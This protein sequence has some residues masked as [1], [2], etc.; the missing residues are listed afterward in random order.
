M[1]L[2]TFPTAEKASKYVAEEIAAYIA[3]KNASNEKTV[4]G[5]AT[6]STPIQVYKELINFHQKG[7]SFK[8]V[9]TFNLDEYYPMGASE[10][11]SYH[12]YMHTHLFDHVD[13]SGENIHIPDGML[14]GD[15]VKEYCKK[16]EQKIKEVGGIDIQLL[17]IGRT[18]HIGFNEPGSPIDSK[19]RLVQLHETTREDAANDFGGLRNVPKMAITMGI[20][21]ILTAK[22]IYLLSLGRRKAEITKTC[23]LGEITSERPASYLQGED[24]VEVIL[25]QEAGLLIQRDKI[26]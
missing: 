12:T 23:L 11:E 25:D 13:I 1:Q 21:T 6:G 10:K 9:I 22:K 14:P 17:G 24:H 5:L 20:E 16:Y 8:N 19:T 18:G 26:N 3:D 7:L 2:N 4:L 15:M